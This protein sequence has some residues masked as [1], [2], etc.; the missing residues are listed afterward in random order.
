MKVASLCK[1]HVGCLTQQRG[2]VLVKKEEEDLVAGEGLADEQV[3]GLYF[4]SG[5]WGSVLH[6][7]ARCVV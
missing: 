3:G 6:D 7:V 1:V 4:E 5:W 2:H